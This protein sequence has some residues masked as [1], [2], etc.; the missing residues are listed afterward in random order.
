M[1]HS[2]I[3]RRILPNGMSV[4][5]LP[6]HKIPKVSVQLWYNVGSKDE[7]SGQKGIAHL[8]E[9][10]IFKGT[11]TLTESDIN[12]ITHKLSG[13]T[14]AFTSHD[15]TGYL[16]DFPSQHWNQALTIM[17][18]CMNNCAFK[19]D[20][21]NSEL[22]AVIQELKMYNDD[23]A[24]SLL[25][26]ML[27]V[28]FTGHPYRYPVIG[29]KHDLWNLKRDALVS[30]YN[31]HYIP[32]NATLV[33][34]GDVDPEDAFAQTEKAF[35]HLVSDPDYVKKEFYFSPDF[36]AQSVILYRDIQQ[37]IVMVAWVI[38]GTTA[39][40]DYVLDLVSWIVGYGKGS[41]LYRLLV[42][43]LELVTEVESFVYDMFE[44]GLFV[45]TFQPKN[46]ADIDVI[47]SKINGYLEQQAHK[48]VTDQELTR[49]R[50]KTKMD[51]ISLIENNQKQAYLLG[52]YYL[53]TGNEHYLDTYCDHPVE[54]LK[55]EI[56]KIIANYLRPAVMH[57][58]KVLP[59]PEKEKPFWIAFQERS[60]AED[61]RVLSRITR[62]T[63]VEEGCCVTNITVKPPQP[64]TFPRAT[65]ADLPNGLRILS[66]HNPQAAKVDIVMEF[67]A[68][69]FYDPENLQGL[70][71]FMMDMLTEGT[72]HYSAAEF[73]QELETHGMSLHAFPGQI[74]LSMLSADIPKGLS[75][76][77]EILTRATFTQ[78][79]IERVRSRLL[80]DISNFWDAPTQFANQLIREVVYRQHPYHKNM[81]GTPE[82]IKAITRE[83]LIQ[84]Y[85][86]HITPKETRLA[87]VGDFD[88]YDIQALITERLGSWNGPVVQDLVYPELLP[89]KPH[90]V[91]YRINRDQIVLCFAGLSVNRYSP[92]YDKIL[93]FDQIFTGGVLGSM[94]SMLFSLREQS[95]LFYTI[96]GSLLAGVSKQPGIALIKTIVSPDRLS[97]AE[98]SITAL[99]D[100]GTRYLTQD[101]F[102]EAQR[103]LIN[104]LVDSF[105]SNRQIAAAFLFLDVYKFPVDYFD[106]RAAQLERI[107]IEEVKQAVPHVLSS[108]K[109]A[110]IRIGRV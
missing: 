7:S 25:E 57:Q 34:V 104:S 17:A 69:H 67:K 47:I 4:L 14:N 99:I 49:A 82:S 60:D 85:R 105:A 28:I 109:M 21:L 97:E 13:Y 79:A 62:E 27:T 75:L 72:E 3:L 84:A 73:A 46:I 89:V 20:L 96:G 10:M 70:E 103:A 55:E 31:H 101:E 1:A 61:A 37:P 91:N 29:Y 78:E 92:D 24:S 65:I 48:L 8:I 102:E 11:K 98:K 15:Y 32:N 58:G 63:P 2:Q 90:V 39:Q 93:L 108:S 12:M 56:Q 19:E 107:T 87:I 59:L 40:L 100:T 110:T 94:S 6:Q 26:D 66:H 18:D 9:H 68:K 81:I 5:V 42:E 64:F 50:K 83:N 51:F 52:K 53:A 43:E 33:I 95:G 38:P 16:F 88:A 80:I 44:H 41:H 36:G 74:T 30:F 23:Y 71:M 86:E 54:G 45:I 77:A 35:A 106:T 76:L 22:K